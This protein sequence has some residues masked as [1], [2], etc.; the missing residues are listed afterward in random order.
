M[1]RFRGGNLHGP[2]SPKLTPSRFTLSKLTLSKL[3]LSNLALSKLTLSRLTLSKFALS[4]LALSKLA[5][6]TKTSD[7][8]VWA[9]KQVVGQGL[10]TCGA[11]MKSAS[12]ESV[13]G[14][15]KRLV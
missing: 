7:T 9:K 2:C 11:I 3:T 12:G 10:V 14:A 4:K 5:L 8:I 1:Q 13:W 6:S 15:V